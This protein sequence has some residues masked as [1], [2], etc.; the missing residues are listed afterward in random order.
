MVFLILIL[1]LSLSGC[2]LQTEPPENAV[3]SDGFYQAYADMSAGL[4][5]IC[6]GTG[7]NSAVSPFCLATDCSMLCL[8]SRGRTRAQIEE[9]TGLDALY[10]AKELDRF[11]TRLQ[12]QKGL[13]TGVSLWTSAPV[14]TSYE[15]MVR[16]LFWA[17]V[18]KGTEKEQIDKWADAVTNGQIKKIAAGVLDPCVFV[19]AASVKGSFEKPFAICQGSFCDCN[20]ITR[21]TDML[22]AEADETASIKGARGF[23]KYYKGKGLA[24]ICILPGKG[25]DIKEFA[26]GIQGEDLLKLWETK[27]PVKASVRIPAFDISS[28]IDLTPFAKDMGIEDAFSKSADLSGISKERLT[29]GRLLHKARVTVS[30]RKV[31]AEAAPSGEELVFDRPFLYEIVDTKTGLPVFAGLVIRP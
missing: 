17:D 23:V 29:A 26:K 18:K 30:G 15:D 6:A 13:C 22:Q 12:D 8:G 20:G 31:K 3:E 9:A 2:S 21:R 24:L 1:A 5:H 28:G 14:E 25:R 4:L 11:G 16:D 10:F 27:S 7:E 19:S